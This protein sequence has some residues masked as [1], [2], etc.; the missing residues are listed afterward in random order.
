M[1]PEGA[2]ISRLPWNDGSRVSTPAVGVSGVHPNV[3][4]GSE[5]KSAPQFTVTGALA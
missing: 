5:V 1:T 3:A 2:P 4:A